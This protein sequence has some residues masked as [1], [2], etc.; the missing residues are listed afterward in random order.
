LAQGLLAVFFIVAGI[1]H[2]VYP[3]S[4]AKIMPHWLPWH[5]GLVVV[6]GLCEIAGG[7][8]VLLAPTRRWAGLGLIA[9][10]LAVLPANVQMLQDAQ[11]AGAHGPW[12]ALLWLRLPAQ[13]LLIAWI[14]RA[15]IRRQPV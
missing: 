15:A 11:A 3:A 12:L 13:L 9:L 6:S 14:W 2:F 1:L 5:G 7:L 10:C 8:G 4:Y